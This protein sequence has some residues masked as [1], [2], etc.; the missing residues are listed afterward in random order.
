MPSRLH[1][2]VEHADDLDDAW[3]YQAIEDHMNRVCD[4]HL[5]AFIAAVADVEAANAGN[6]LGAIFCRPSVG[7]GRHTAHCCSEARPIA[8]PRRFAGS[9]FRFS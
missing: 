1:A 2:V 8:N 7:K 4:R 3:R 9:F 6:E 5:A